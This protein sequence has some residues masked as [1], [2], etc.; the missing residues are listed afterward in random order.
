[1]DRPVVM[2]M[3]RNCTMKHRWKWIVAVALFAMAGLAFWAWQGGSARAV[4]VG[5]SRTGPAAELVY[6][7]GFI[8]AQQPVSV[9]SR[10]TAPVDR[11]LVEEGD[12]V[13]RGQPLVLLIDDEQRGLLAQAAA[14]RR[15]LRLAIWDGLREGSALQKVWAD[16]LLRKKIPP[17]I[18]QIKDRVLR[19][20][21]QRS[22]AL[23][24]AHEQKIWQ[25][26]F[27]ETFSALTTL[28][29]MREQHA[30]V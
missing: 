11:I 30:E 2:P 5:E 26:M 3:R 17:E 1:M 29:P 24:V 16:A 14:Q 21:I 20:I 27:A 12:R 18:D 15:A 28:F 7:T 19:W 13:K 25:D 6:A 9:S 22:P 4:R 23:D 8:E 10:I